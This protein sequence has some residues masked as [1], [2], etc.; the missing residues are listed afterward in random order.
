MQDMDIRGAGNLLGAEQSGFISEIGFETYQR[1]LNEAMFEL[2]EEEFNSVFEDETSEKQET[3]DRA[4][5]TD[6]QIDTDLELLFPDDYIS[7]V[8]E[9]IRQYRTLDNIETEDK[10]HEFELQLIDRFGP[11]PESTR[12]LMNVVRMRWMAGLL[13]F[14]KIILKNGKMLIWFV[15]N[16]QSPYYQSPVFENVIRFVQ[17]HQGLFQ[18]KEAKDKLTMTAEP[19]EGI[20]K[21]MSTLK[22]IQ[23]FVT[24]NS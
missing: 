18:M 22:R 11:L 16:Q 3:Q 9:R 8:A 7:N 6:C 13:G 4:Y 17:K 20:S 15:S 19:I 21:A 10:L 23:D 1:I 12:E 14:E 5:T 24:A 2:R